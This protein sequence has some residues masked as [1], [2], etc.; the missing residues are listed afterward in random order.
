MGL[1]WHSVLVFVDDLTVTCETVEQGLD[2]LKQVLDQFRK[3]N[4]KPKVSK[5]TLFQTH[6]CILGFHVSAEGIRENPQ[7][8]EAIRNLPFRKQSV[9]LEPCLGA[10]ILREVSTNTWPKLHFRSL[11]C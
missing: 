11:P 5:C 8:V 6:A 1:A 10:L 4:F 7:R 3:V 2:I 9:K